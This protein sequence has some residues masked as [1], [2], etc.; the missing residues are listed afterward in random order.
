[1]KPGTL[2][3]FA[4]SR[5]PEDEHY[6]GFSVTHPVSEEISH[7]SSSLVQKSQMV[8]NWLSNKSRIIALIAMEQEL[9]IGRK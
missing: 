3:S 4:G 9:L 8:T 2:S 1:M 5:S 7:N 6:V